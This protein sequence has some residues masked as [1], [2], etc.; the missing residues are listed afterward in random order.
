MNESMIAPDPR[1][2]VDPYTNIPNA[3]GQGK[4]ATAERPASPAVGFRWFDTTLSEP[5]WFNGTVWKDA[6]GTTV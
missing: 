6:A 5:I 1:E 2:D 3:L 4:G